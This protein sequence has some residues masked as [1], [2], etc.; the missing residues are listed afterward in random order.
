MAAFIAKGL[1][2]V[3]GWPQGFVATLFVAAVTSAPD[4]AVTVA[5]LRLG[6]LDLAI[7]N[8]FGGNMFNIVL[9]A[10]D[11]L[12]YL[13]GPL[14]ADVSISHTASAFSAM[15]M[16]GLA[17]VGLVLRP[18]SR[19]L[20]TVSWISLLLLAVYLLSSLFLYLYGH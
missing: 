14:L 13:P 9:V 11:D 7:G 16:I 5:A 12:A 3:M 15:M 4:L 10:F 17:I 1:A 18:A 6:A 8:L 19:V 20:R 2:A